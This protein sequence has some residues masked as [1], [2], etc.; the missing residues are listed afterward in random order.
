MNDVL[1]HADDEFRSRILWQLE[2]WSKGK[3]DSDIIHWGLLLPEFLRNVW[4]KQKSLKTARISGRLMDLAFSSVESFEELSEIILPL[5]TA[6]E[7]E[8]L[9]LP[10][11]RKKKDGIIDLYP[12]KALALLYAVLP[13]NVAYWPFDIEDI[14]RRI[15]EA[16][17]NL[18]SDERL[19]ELNRKWKSR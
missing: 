1:L 2:V 4:P 6:V 18:S 11:L 5:V 10:N 8:H 3:G 16:D 15:S 17:E 13:D 14:L 12:K 9:R 7:S 19:I